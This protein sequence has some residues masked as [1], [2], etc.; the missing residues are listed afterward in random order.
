MRC[1][2]TRSPFPPPPLLRHSRDSVTPGPLCPSGLPHP[3]SAT[4]VTSRRHSHPHR[5]CRPVQV[6]SAAADSPTTA[7]CSLFCAYT[8]TF[9]AGPRLVATALAVVPCSP[10][11]R[12][13]QRSGWR[14]TSSAATVAGWSC[15]RSPGRR[16]E[17][18]AVPFLRHSR[19]LVALPTTAAARQQP[20]SPPPHTGPPFPSRLCLSGRL[21]ES[22]LA[23]LRA[24]FAT[25]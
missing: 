4:A 5:C 9:P 21:V 8:G 15:R 12:G 7:C 6:P 3:A 11:R 25:C 1:A 13:S 24:T 23:A 17:T 19:R 18:T 2:C 22:E 16:R 10:T 20:P 14:R